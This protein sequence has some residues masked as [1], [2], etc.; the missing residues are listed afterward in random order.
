[1]IHFANDSSTQRNIKESASFY[2]QQRT[3]ELLNR[4]EVL[5]YKNVAA[6]LRDRGGL[7]DEDIGMGN[8]KALNQLIAH[9]RVVFMPEKRLIWVSTNPY[10]LGAFVAYDLNEVFSEYPNLSDDREIKVDSLTIVAD[11][12]LKTEEYKKYVEFCELKKHLQKITKLSR[13]EFD[14]MEH[15]KA[16]RIQEINPQYYRAYELAGDLYKART[17]WDL[18]IEAYK[19]AL[20]LE[21]ATLKE[22][23]NIEIA[24]SECLEAKKQEN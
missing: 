2:R 16:L 7:Y 23:R 6:I 1:M 20:D 21:I 10:Q 4:Y 5:D 22:R 3:E 15:D 13:V 18:A 17:Q 9:H 8:E 12:F 19:Q 24:L 11:P 14:K